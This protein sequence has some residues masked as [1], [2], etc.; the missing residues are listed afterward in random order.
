MN[1]YSSE[2]RAY[3]WYHAYDESDMYAAVG[4]ELDVYQQEIRLNDGTT[5][6]FIVFHGRTDGAWLASDSPV[7]CVAHR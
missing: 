1:D 3:L 7:D 4:Q 5:H 6:P 2:R